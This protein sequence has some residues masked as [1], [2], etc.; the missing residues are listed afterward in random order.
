MSVVLL[1]S[2]I[3]GTLCIIISFYLIVYSRDRL[4]GSFDSALSERISYV[5]L[6]NRQGLSKD[7]FHTGLKNTYDDRL[8]NVSYNVDLGHNRLKTVTQ[9]KDYI[10]SVFDGYTKTNNQ[11][12]KDIQRTFD[13]MP[14]QYIAAFSDEVKNNT[15]RIKSTI[16]SASQVNT[17][18]SKQVDDLSLRSQ[19]VQTS[20]QLNNTRANELLRNYMKNGEL[21]AYVDNMIKVKEGQEWSVRNQ[22]IKAGFN[23]LDN[24]YSERKLLIPILKTSTENKTRLISLTN[25]VD[26]IKYI[27]PVQLQQ[28]K[29]PM[30][31]SQLDPNLLKSIQNKSAEINTVKQRIETQLAPVF[32]TKTEYDTAAERLKNISYPML[33]F[34]YPNKLNVNGRV[35]VGKAPTTNTFEVLD[36][37]S[38]NWA[39]VVQNGQTRVV[40]SRGDGLGLNI[41]TANTD[42]TKVALNIQNGNDNLFTLKNNGEVDSGKVISANRLNSAAQLCIN[43][44]CITRADLDKIARINILAPRYVK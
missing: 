2:G 4:E 19:S 28:Y 22:N 26:G 6:N 42:P 20:L 37:N 15:N 33:Q 41:N 12:I 36:P 3:I 24:I 27:T 11:S 21:S 29:F 35:G 43:S 8:K 7:Y 18:Q 44:T 10:S 34:S 17:R 16:D 32:I 31:D 30:S 5:N 9:E 38:G 23:N 1:V 14:V 13:G 40:M 39:G 25:N